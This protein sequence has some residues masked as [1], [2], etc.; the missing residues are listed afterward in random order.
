LGDVTGSALA[1]R[2]GVGVEPPQHAA[3][4]GLCWP[5]LSSHPAALGRLWLLQ[6]SNPNRQDYSEDHRAE[7]AA[8]SR[9]ES[10]ARHFENLPAG[11]VF[12]RQAI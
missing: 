10:G 11:Q 9:E 4:Q 6:R 8:A 1:G 5:V 3:R 12:I 2:F 7:T